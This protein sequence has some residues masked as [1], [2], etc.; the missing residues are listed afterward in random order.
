M[1][2]NWLMSAAC[3]VLLTA[4]KLQAQS[5]FSVVGEPNDAATSVFDQGKVRTYALTISSSDLNKI[6]ARPSAEQWVRGTLVYEGKTY[7]DVGV[8]Y[9]GSVGGFLYPCTSQ[10]TIG[11]ANGRKLGKHRR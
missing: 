1:S 3:L 8:R 6:N 9:K 11:A 2:R 10:Q 7:R 4:A 5:S